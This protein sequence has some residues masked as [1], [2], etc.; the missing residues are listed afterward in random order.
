[1]TLKGEIE[2]IVR[3]E[4]SKLDNR[5]K[6]RKKKREISDRLERHSFQPMK[7]LLE[8]L[9]AS[10]EPEYLEVSIFEPDAYVTLL[11][12]NEG[13]RGSVEWRITIVGNTRDGD[14]AISF[15]ETIWFPDVKTRDIDFF[16]ERDILRYLKSKIGR[17][18]ARYLH[19]QREQ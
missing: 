10:V 4:T 19:E 5:E 17:G 16:D 7:E 18:I 6:K 3:R 9:A 11:P 2:K 14:P 12:K 13:K 8:E 15:S 1:M